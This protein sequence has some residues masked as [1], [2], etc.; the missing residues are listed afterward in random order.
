MFPDN[1][2]ESI[3]NNGLQMR[4]K[5]RKSSK[6]APIVIQALENKPLSLGVAKM[7]GKIFR[8]IMVEFIPVIYNKH[9][10]IQFLYS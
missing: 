3:L 10:I 1:L 8:T 4:R 9:K 6:E 5:D 7:N 2:S